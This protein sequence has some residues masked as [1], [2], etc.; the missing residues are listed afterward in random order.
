MVTQLDMSVDF[1]AYWIARFLQLSFWW[2][3]LCEL[4]VVL[5]TLLPCLYLKRIINET[6]IRIVNQEHGW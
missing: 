2:I 6:Y 5:L 3:W 4:T 1:L